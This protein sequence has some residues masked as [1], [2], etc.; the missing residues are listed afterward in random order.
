M[1]RLKLPSISPSE[2][3]SEAVWQSRRTW[4]RHAGMGIVAAGAGSLAPV[5]SSWAQSE[6][7]LL[8]ATPNPDYQLMDKPTSEKDITSYNNYYEFGTGKSDPFENAHK[9]QTRPWTVSVEGEVA[10]PRTFDIDDLL[11]LAPIEERVYRLRCV[12][13]WSMVIPWSGYSLSTLLKAVEPTSKAKFVEFT[14]VVQKD[15]MPGVGSRIIDWPYVEGLRID[16]AMH[17]LAMLV[18]GVYGKQLP[19]QNGAPLRLVV[20]WKYGFKSGKSIVKIRLLENMPMTSW[21]KIA[22]QEYGFYANVN[23]QVPHPRWSQAT[24]RRIGDGFFAPRVDTLM[25]NGYAEQVASLYEGM[26]LRKNY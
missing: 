21:V 4:L 20:P 10:R 11:K 15:N 12:E 24:E 14:T 22:P 19:N 6:Q 23:P 17:P 8:A 25:Y 1:S 16:E 7:A 13:A 9:L 26:D 5:A 3:T 2:I 18:L